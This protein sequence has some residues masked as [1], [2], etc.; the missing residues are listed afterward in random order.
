MYLENYNNNSN[1]YWRQLKGALTGLYS[2]RQQTTRNARILAEVMLPLSSLGARWTA[3]LHV[4]SAGFGGS[5]GIKHI[6][7]RWQGANN[8][9]LYD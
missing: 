3:Q 9:G 7:E 1:E 8:S 5:A 4:P 6:L 2:V